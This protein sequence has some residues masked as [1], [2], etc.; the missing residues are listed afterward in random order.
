M[1]RAAAESHYPA[2]ASILVVDDSPSNLALMF[3]LLRDRYTVKGANSGERALK[4]ARE[5][6]PPDLILLDVIIAGLERL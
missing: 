6:R 4:I 1:N 3:R 5:G 2:R